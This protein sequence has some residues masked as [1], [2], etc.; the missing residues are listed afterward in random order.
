MTNTA[1]VLE[2]FALFTKHTCFVALGATVKVPR[3]CVNT[4]RRGSQ[5]EWLRDALYR[6]G[7]RIAS[8][9]RCCICDSHKAQFNRFGSRSRMKDQRG[10]EQF[11]QRVTLF[12][13]SR[14]G[15]HG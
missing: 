9:E 2:V 5:N 8:L 4:P 12:R 10:F 7:L 6:A 13:N 3:Q 14:G 15:E 11:R 1:L